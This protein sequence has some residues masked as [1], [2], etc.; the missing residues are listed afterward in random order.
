MSE[1]FP[2]NPAPV[3][4]A[5]IWAASAI[6]GRGERLTYESIALEMDCSIKVAWARVN[7]AK[8]RL[9]WPHEVLRRLPEPRPK[10]PPPRLSA[11]LSSAYRPD[12]ATDLAMLGLAPTLAD[13]LGRVSIG[14]LARAMDMP[15]T[16][17][18]S[19]VRRL[20]SLDRW[21][22]LSTKTKPTDPDATGDEDIIEKLEIMRTGQ[23]RD[24]RG[25]IDDVPGEAPWSGRGHLHDPE[26][27][28]RRAQAKACQ[29]Y[30]DEWRE[31]TSTRAH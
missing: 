24:G 26:R 20:R 9:A 27:Q 11:A 4:K 14:D 29:R 22:H 31:M 12:D 19:R 3:Q 2:S 30:L 6:V 15:Y 17:A 10:P 25:E 8:R 5:T 28:R 7:E 23:L 13:R 18:C 21:P 1:R 16:T